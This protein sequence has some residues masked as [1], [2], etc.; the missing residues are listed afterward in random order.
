MSDS[1]ETVQGQVQGTVPAAPAPQPKPKKQSVSEMEE[2]LKRLELEAKQLEVLEKKAN[3][4]DLQ[5]R[6]AERELKR[7]AARQR[8]R[9]NGAVL[10]QQERDQAAQERHCNHRKG[11][12]GMEAY[13]GGQGDSPQYAVIKHIFANGDMWIRCMRCRKTWKP[14]IEADFYFDGQGNQVP[15]TSDQ[16]G[17][18]IPNGG[19]FS[20]EKYQQAVRDYLEAKAFQTKNATSSSIPLQFSDGGKFFRDVMH[21]VTLR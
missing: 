16:F 19:T 9:G 4:Q 10:R 17:R 21:G 13:Q 12:S 7:E 20:S 18:V 2:E 11:G 14:P 15:P 6:L 3:L 5:E 8:S 1:N